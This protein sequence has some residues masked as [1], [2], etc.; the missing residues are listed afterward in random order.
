MELALSGIQA[1]PDFG[2]IC[3][4]LYVVASTDEEEKNGSGK[5]ENFFSGQ[6]RGLSTADSPDASGGGVGTLRI[7]NLQKM[8]RSEASILRR[9]VEAVLALA[10]LDAICLSSQDYG[11]GRDGRGDPVLDALDKIRLP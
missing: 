8:G 4:N 2:S 10:R 9:F 6:S 5:L 3:H 1:R 11:A 7:T